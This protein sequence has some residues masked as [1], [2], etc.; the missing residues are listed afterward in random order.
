[1]PPDSNNNVCASFGRNI[2]PKKRG[3]LPHPT[4]HYNL[5]SLVEEPQ[6]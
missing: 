2:A 5:P 1:M 3:A 6:L 4:W